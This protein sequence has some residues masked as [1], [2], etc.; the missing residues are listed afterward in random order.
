MSQTNAP[1][2]PVTIVLISGAEIRTNLA[3]PSVAAVLRGIENGSGAL[4]CNDGNCVW[5]LRAEAIAG[6]RISA[7]D[8][9][10]FLAKGGEK[11]LQG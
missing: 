3:P 7:A 11:A 9:E 8:W 1:T 6:M 5:K 10:Q 2:V 4:M